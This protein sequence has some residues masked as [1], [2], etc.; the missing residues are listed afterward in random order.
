MNKHIGFLSSFIL[1]WLI[2]MILMPELSSCSDEIKSNIRDPL[3]THID[4][5]VNPA[6]DFFMYANGNWFRQNP[7][8]A[9]ERS[10]GIFL[11]VQ[12]TI[13]AQVLKICINASS[14][15]TSGS[16]S[17]KQKLGDFY[18]S[19]MDSVSID[20]AGLSGLVSMFSE[21][22]KINDLKDL[23]LAVAMIHEV[24]SGRSPLFNLDISQDDRISSKYVVEITQGGLSLPDRRY[25]FDRDAR[26]DSTRKKFIKHLENVYRMMGMDSK[27]A[28][29]AASG[30]MMLETVLAKVSRKSE[31]TR[32]PLENY[33]KLTFAQLAGLTPHFNW[34]DF[35]N[36]AG[37]HDVD[38]VIVRQ[39]DF[40]KGLDAILE[41]TSV[42]DLKNY[43]KYQL[44]KG[45]SYSLDDRT[46]G[47]FFDFYEKTLAGISTP[48][49]R[50]KR[51]VTQ[52]N[53]QLGDLIGQVYVNE[54]LPKG[55][56]EK[57]LEIGNAVKQIYAE[58]I[59]KLDW[60]SDQTKAKALIKLDKIIMK[61]GYPDKWKD[62]SALDI[63]RDSYLQNTIAARKWWY[64]YHIS[65][66]GKPVDRTEWDMEPQ[67]YNAYYNPSNNEICVPGCN[68][69]LPGYERRM[70][71]D[72]LLYSV[73][74]GS[75]F[76]HEITHGFDDV[77]RKY[78]VDGNLNNWW[79]SSDSIK[80]CRKTRLIIK[81]FDSYIAVDTLH[82]N[83]S[84][85][86]GENIADLGGIMIGY[87]A[88]RKTKQYLENI[89]IAGLSPDQR[90]FLGYALAWMENER[91]ETVST[92]VRSDEHSPAKFRVIGPLSNMPEFYRTFGVK[93]GN[94]MW[95]PDSLR[96]KIW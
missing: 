77:G 71:D 33:N 3:V 58:R 89:K 2:S 17:I 38:S 44:L 67:T 69:I 7:I 5:S 91:P 56:R 96:V 61:V 10:N 28:G 24:V 20:K 95:R 60:M 30:Q 72:A 19:G 22:D 73:I 85:T 87:E 48:R 81:Q 14:S 16:G 79:T 31:D 64:N 94:S 68:I 4:P 42:G 82:I 8:P 18:Y 43:L 6:E 26:A 62:M 59:R 13:N 11:L 52:T 25:Y 93:E 35:M 15:K 23:P 76:G 54:Y 51:V 9:S 84:F 47:E 75:T 34:N 78:D 86:Q 1:P 90:F 41:N 12:D 92:Q 80:F 27:N 63:T 88:F 45:L 65:K 39:P 83:G 50:W 53:G 49:P 46:Y 74:G 36:Y 32:D 40:M 55:T 29:I 57:L 70:A 21:I 66:Y 37:L